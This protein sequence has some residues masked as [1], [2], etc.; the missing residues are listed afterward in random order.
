MCIRDRAQQEGETVEVSLNPLLA[1]HFDRL[2]GCHETLSLSDE[3]YALRTSLCSYSDLEALPWA[4]DGT[5]AD[6]RAR[7]AFARQ[8]ASWRTML[9]SQPP[10]QRLDW[11]HKWESSDRRNEER[12]SQRPVRS[13]GGHQL[14]YSST[15]TIGAL[16]DLL[17]VRL[18]RGCS[19]RLTF[20][21]NGGSA[22]SDPSASKNEKRWETAAV[23][24]ENGFSST[25]PRIRI[26]FQQVWPGA[27]P[28]MYDKFNV[29]RQA[30]D[31]ENHPLFEPR[32][33]M[34]SPGRGVCNGN[35]MHLL[36]TA[37]QD[38]AESLNWRWSR[39]DA[40]V[41]VRIQRLSVSVGGS[42][43]SRRLTRVWTGSEGKE[44]IL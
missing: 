34:E 18:L 17:E 12:R 40:F 10:M 8:E 6:A 9:I 39:S 2:L 20:F 11:W 41:P 21:V 14:D 16:W 24:T 5:H 42:H 32:T 37:C 36:I 1:T 22:N 4:R 44:L 15:V 29:Q 3:R 28:S 27:G 13:G 38:D 33:G 7:Q 19:L 43:R 35:G 30:W 25:L 26:Q 31:I 23:A